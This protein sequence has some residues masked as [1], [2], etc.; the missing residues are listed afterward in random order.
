MAKPGKRN[1]HA[2]LVWEIRKLYIATQISVIDSK[3]PPSMEE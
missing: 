2:F 3:I 1:K